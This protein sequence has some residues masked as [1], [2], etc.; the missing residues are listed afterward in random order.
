MKKLALFKPSQFLENSKIAQKSPKKKL[1]IQIPEISS[2]L[3]DLIEIERNKDLSD[4]Q[5]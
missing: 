5:L 3:S 1:S 2:D 4:D